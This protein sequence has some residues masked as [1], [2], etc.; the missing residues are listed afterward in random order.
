MA[1]L[2]LIVDQEK[3]PNF[4]HAY[5]LRLLAVEIVMTM[6][7]IYKNTQELRRLLKVVVKRHRHIG[8]TVT[9]PF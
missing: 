4:H 5:S 8:D 2:F 9:Q 1:K 3:I 7:Q 6:R